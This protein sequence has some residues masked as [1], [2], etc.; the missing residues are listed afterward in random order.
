MIYAALGFVLG[1]IQSYY[2]LTVPDTPPG[3]IRWFLILSA[4]VIYSLAALQLH[5]FWV[6]R[7]NE[8]R[9]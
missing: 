3:L 7:S 2:W 1:C 6:R 9:R 4:P 8:R 5:R